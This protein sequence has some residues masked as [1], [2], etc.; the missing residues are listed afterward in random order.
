MR[1]YVAERSLEEANRAPRTWWYE[2][3]ALPLSWVQHG[4]KLYEVTIRAKLYKPTKSRK[5]ARSKP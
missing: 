1:V 5:R 2:P 3:F 4:L